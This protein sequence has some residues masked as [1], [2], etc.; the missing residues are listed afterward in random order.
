M[1]LFLAEPGKS[2]TSTPVSSLGFP[3]LKCVC[4]LQAFPSASEAGPVNRS[5]N[6]GAIDSSMSG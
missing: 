2:P 3:A 5:V 6:C 1:T 4:V